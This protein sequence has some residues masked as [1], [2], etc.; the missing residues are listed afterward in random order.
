[1]CCFQLNIQLLPSEKGDCR[2]IL[3]D[4]GNDQFFNRTS[5]KRKNSLLNHWI[6]FHLML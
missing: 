5:L 6:N 1:M 2:P 4:F 3:D